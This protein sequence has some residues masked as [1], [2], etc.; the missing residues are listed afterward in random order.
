VEQVLVEHP[1]VAE[2]VV[3]GVPDDRWGSRVTAL[4]VPAPG[5]E[6][7]P[8][9]LA[10]HVGSRLAGYK[11]PRAVRLVEAIPRTVSGK[12]DRRWAQERARELPPSPQ[13]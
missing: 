13:N 6:L 1:G 2:A 3:V 4:G 7:D 12:L 9:A 5:A 11:R 10:V 8:D